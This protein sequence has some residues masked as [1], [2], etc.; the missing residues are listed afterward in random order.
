[1]EVSRNEIMGKLHEVQSLLP[2]YTE[3]VNKYNDKLNELVRKTNSGVWYFTLG[4]SIVIS[5]IFEMFAERVVGELF[6]GILSVAVCIGMFIFLSKIKNNKIEKLNLELDHI[7]DEYK[8]FYGGHSEFFTAIGYKYWSHDAIEYMF[9]LMDTNRADNYRELMNLTDDYIHRSN[10]ERQNEEL[11]M[12][13]DQLNREV[14]AVK[15]NTY[16]NS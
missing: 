13:I 16:L 12:K 4:R 5:L 2:E 10:L 11:N 6:A 3:L 1:M 8:E 9:E 15:W 14:E 7:E